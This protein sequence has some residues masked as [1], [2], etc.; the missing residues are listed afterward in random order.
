MTVI[1][2]KIMCVYF[3]EKRALP[4]GFHDPKERS[5]TTEVGISRFTK[6]Q[7]RTF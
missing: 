1:T 2:C 3:T 7:Q 5:R 4:K 6:T